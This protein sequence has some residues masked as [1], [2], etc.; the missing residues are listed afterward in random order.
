MISGY[1][2]IEIPDTGN[3]NGIVVRNMV[4]MLM[5][6]EMNG[7]LQASKPVQ[8]MKK[9]LIRKNEEIKELRE[10]LSR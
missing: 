3:G 1:P 8:Q 5:L 7:K 9:L 6:K 10:R 2:F 4:S